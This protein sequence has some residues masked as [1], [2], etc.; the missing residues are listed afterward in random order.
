MSRNRPLFLA[1]ILANCG[2]CLE[3]YLVL[4]CVPKLDHRSVFSLAQPD[5]GC[6]PVYVVP[7]PVLL[8][9]R[10]LH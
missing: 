10:S 2:D 3:N 4:E 5:E 1:Q 8:P 6:W 9:C 7:T